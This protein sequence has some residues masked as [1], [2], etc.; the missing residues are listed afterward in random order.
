MQDK[1]LHFLRTASGY[2]SGEEIS[3]QLKISRAGI[4]KYI[5]E[6]RKEGY[7][8]VAVPHLGYRLLSSPDRLTSTEIQNGLKT[9]WIGKK[10][11]C[12]ES[13]PSTMDI[14]FQRG[15]DGASDGTV[16]CA[17]NQTKGKGRLGRSWVSPKGKGI[18]MSVLLRPHMS[19]VDVAQITL[20]SAVAV[21]ESIKKLTGLPVRIKWPNDILVED[22]E[23]AGGDS[24]TVP[25][26]PN[27]SRFSRSK[28]RFFFAKASKESILP[29]SAVA[30]LNSDRLRRGER[31]FS[32]ADR[33]TF[34]GGKKIAG[35][36]TEL[37]AEMDRVRFVIVGIGVNVNTP[38]SQLPP[39]AT[40]I[41][42]ESGKKA[43]RI[44]LV[45]EIL[46]SLEGWYNGLRER[47]FASAIARW[48]ELSS[49]LGRRV[50]VVDADGYIE[51]EAVD[52]DENGGLIIRSPT[53][54]TIKRM[55]GDVV[56]IG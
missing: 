28:D 55:T 35:I 32:E 46:F 27:R 41:K 11:E 16:V 33:H 24:E 4:W 42:H 36:L 29:C 26:G 17:E 45:Q 9:R 8:I 37:S 7:D 31:S 52:L 40:S 6:F 10:M 47:G 48:K 1:I 20:L 2:L 54:V 23:T 12:Y 25:R 51:G 13:V 30:Q 39:A 43:S 49:T 3:R 38:L 53:G 14:A 19:P 56:R 44:E 18:Y 34:L 5:Q 15:M 22:K 21:C 50:R